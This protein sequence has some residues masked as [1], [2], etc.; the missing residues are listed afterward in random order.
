MLYPFYQMGVFYLPLKDNFKEGFDY[1]LRQTAH[2]VHQLS[3]ETLITKVLSLAVCRDKRTQ[4]IC[5]K[6]SVLTEDPWMCHTLETLLAIVQ[7]W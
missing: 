5:S 3:D 4:N 2:I 7:C 1:V 6:T